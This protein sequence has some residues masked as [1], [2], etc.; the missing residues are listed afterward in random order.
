MVWVA[1]GESVTGTA[2]RA[3]NLPCQDAFRYRTIGTTGEWL[4]IATAD[5]AGSASHSDIGATLV[6]DE[7]VQRVEK[8]DPDSL[9]TREG[10]TRLFA[11]VRIALHDKAECLDVRSRELA[12]TGLFAFLGP[13]TAAFGQIGDGAIVIGHGETLRT[14]FWPEPSEYANA[15]DFLTDEHFADVIQFHTMSEPIHEVALLTD[16]LQRLAL[17]FAARSVHLPFFRPLFDHLRTTTDPESLVEPFRNF[18]DSPR[19]N[20]RTDDD[21]TLV[22]AVRP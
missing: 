6:C 11:D 7:F 3:R 4:A 20:E 15:T 12:C 8:L 22:F 1:L 10:M 5:G 19:I 13:T 14:I 9:F 17:D 21:K 18:L 16:G 2:H